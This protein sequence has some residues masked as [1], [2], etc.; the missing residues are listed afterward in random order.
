MKKI[1]LSCLMTLVLVFSFGCSKQPDTLQ[2]SIS[3]MPLSQDQ[4]EIVGLLSTYN[5][6]LFLFEYKTDEVYNSA[7]FW[8]EVYKDGKLVETPAKISYYSNEGYKFDGKLALTITNNTN[9]QWMITAR[10]NG[11]T[12]SHIGESSLIKE[13][14]IGSASSPIDAAVEIEDGKEIVL[15]STMFFDGQITTYSEQQMYVEDPE[16]LKNYSYAHIVKCKFNK[17]IT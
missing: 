4:M 9:Y 17:F 3:L 11:A 7:E 16:L 14:S 6:D 1:L 8:V 13:G 2:N 15:Y 12:Y 10:E 5:Q